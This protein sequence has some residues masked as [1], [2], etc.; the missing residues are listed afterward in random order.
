MSASTGFV[1]SKLPGASKEAVG[2]VRTFPSLSTLFARLNAREQR[3]VIGG[4]ALSAASLVLILVILPFAGR[5]S[6]REQS[7]AA[8]RQQLARLIALVTTTTSVQQAVDSMRSGRSTRAGRIFRGPTSAL[9]AAKLQELLRTYAEAS[10]V[11]LADVDVGGEPA[12]D[13]T[14]LTAIPVK[15][16][17]DGDIYGLADLLWHIEHG[18]KLLIVDEMRLN[19]RSPTDDGRQRLSWTLNLRGPFVTSAE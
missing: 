4:A 3:V 8:K 14:G 19:T 2:Y 11:D 10:R 18:E 5:W 16:S 6:A 9:A 12:T 15:L 13:S 1:F 7:I 17:A